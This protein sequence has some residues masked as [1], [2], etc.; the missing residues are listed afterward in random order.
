[1][2][3]VIGVDG[4]EYGPATQEQVRQWILENRVNAQSL[5]RLE[6]TQEWKPLSA[7]P[8]FADAFS[9][10]PPP[11]PAT[12]PPFSPPLPKPD[13]EAMAAA[14]LAQDYRIEI[15]SCISRS[16]G[17]LTRHFWLLVGA[18]F[19]LGLIQGAVPFFAGVCM[20]ACIFCC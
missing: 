16:W 10:K 13:P 7:L 17:L 18:A 12:P 14:I 20:A 1:M 2:Y 15:G 8:E 9:F 11:G 3:K 6:G 4:Q 5:A 19:V